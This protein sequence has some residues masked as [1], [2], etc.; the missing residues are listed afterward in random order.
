MQE[1]RRIKNAIVR[2]PTPVEPTC[3]NEGRREY[4]NMPQKKTRVLT[5]RTPEPP[6]SHTHF[7]IYA[8]PYCYGKLR[9]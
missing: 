3:K 1:M 9:C 8:I 5:R 6:T 7:S 4:Q 2:A